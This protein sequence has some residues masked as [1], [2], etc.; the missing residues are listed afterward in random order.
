MQ[1]T[2]TLRGYQ[3]RILFS[4]L[5]N[6]RDSPGETFTVMLPRQAGKNEVSAALVSNLLVSR[7]AEGGSIVVCAPTLYPQASISFERTAAHLRAG[8]KRFGLAFAIEGHTLRCGSASAVFLSGSPTANVAGH[9]ASI[10]LIGDEAQDLDEDWF[11]RQFRPMTASTGAATVLFGTPWQ[12]DSLL[13]KAVA[14]NRRHDDA[15]TDP[16]AAFHPWHNQAS[17]RDVAGHLPA[18]GRYVHQERDRLGADHPVF[19][20]QYELVAAQAERRL[21]SPAQVWSLEGAFGPLAAPVPG[22][23]YTGGLDFAGEGPGGDATVLTIARI[24]DEGAEVVAVTVWR[25]EP[26]DLLAAEV[27]ALAR[28][29]RLERLVCD[30][31]GMGAPLAAGLRRALGP[32]VESLI[33][34]RPEKSALGFD[35]IAAASTGALRIAP[36]LTPGLQALWDEL[37]VCRADPEPGGQLSWGAPPGRHDDCV[38]SLALCL[39]AARGTGPARLARGRPGR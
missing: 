10:L 26:F 35:L 16:R 4:L 9:T 13:E 23:R 2:G 6:I 27:Q 21:F 8:A 37:R 20:S 30:A 25:G 1:H 28:Q 7:Q 12:G 32:R 3:A 29:W 11:N 24:G 31:T 17:W 15:A 5:W 38:A 33:F 39:R 36:P 18:Y 22:E 14:A 19:L 34:S